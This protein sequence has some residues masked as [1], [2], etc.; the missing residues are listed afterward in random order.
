ME[1]LIGIIAAASLAGIAG[2]LF[3]ERR[4][5]GRLG[6]MEALSESRQQLLTFVTAERDGLLFELKAEQEARREADKSVAALKERSESLPLHF[7]NLSAKLLEQSSL[8]LS[9][10]SEKNL[11]SVLAP[12]KERFQEFQKKVDE[13]YNAEA[14]ERHTL[15]AEIAS[16]VATHEKM[17]TETANLTHALKGNSKVQ[18]NW[19]EH[20][21]QMLLESCGLR[22]GEEFITQGRDLK[23]KSDDGQRL[24]PDILVRQPDNKHIIVDSKVSL[25]HYEQYINAADDAARAQALALYLSS[26]RSHIKGLA[27]KNYPDAKGPHGENLGSPDFVLMFMPIEGAYMLALQSDAS[28]HGF[29]NSQNVMMVSP[30]TLLPILRTVS[31]IWKQAAQN[32]NALEIA[33]Q[34]GNLYDKFVTFMESMEKIGR[35]LGD[36]RKTYDEAMNRLTHGHGNLIART[37]KL[38]ELGAK[39]SKSLPPNLRAEVEEEEVPPQL[40]SAET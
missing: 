18:G 40:E 32:K 20:V 3:G 8:K 25:V 23:L 16:I 29:G 1:L 37:E 24:Q 22:E 5:R 39:T 35:S 6:A 36:T 19:G 10:A 11:A 17:C 26:V 9:E 27:S 15:K 28:L 4:A 38:R 31:G 12:F 30:A 13:V 33:R 7:E 34:G 21:L 14:R 2:Y